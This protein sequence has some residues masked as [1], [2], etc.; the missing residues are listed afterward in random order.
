MG[1]FFN[2]YVLANLVLL[3]LRAIREKEG[4]ARRAAAAF[5]ALTVVTSVMPQSHELRYYL[6]WMLVL[7]ALNLWLAC[8]DGATRSPAGP[9]ALGV[10][11]ALACGLVI[12]ITK[13]TW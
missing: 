1:G 6:Y 12:M 3:A 10:G 7:V 13:A 2:L 8:R 5:A 4:P 11:A 9:A